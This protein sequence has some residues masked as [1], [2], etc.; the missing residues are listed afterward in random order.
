MS[1]P[2]SMKELLHVVSML[3]SISL[4]FKELFNIKYAQFAVACFRD[5][6]SIDFLAIILSVGSSLA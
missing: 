4:I 2:F 1:L 5:F 3:I 6:F